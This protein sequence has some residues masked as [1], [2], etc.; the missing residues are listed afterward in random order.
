MNFKIICTDRNNYEIPYTTKIFAG[1]EIQVRIGQLPVGYGTTRYIKNILIDGL[2]KSSDMFMELMML[3]DALKRCAS[4]VVITADLHYLP[5]ARQD[6]VCSAGESYSLAQFTSLLKGLQADRLI[7]DDVHSKVSVDLMEVL[8]IEVKLRQQ[9]VL[10]MSYIESGSMHIVAPDKGAE[11]KASRVAY[12]TCNE[13]IQYHKIRNPHSGIIEKTELVLGDQ[14]L[15]NIDCLIV[16]D[17]CDGGRTFVPI[18]EDLLSRGAKSVSLCVTHAILPYGLDNLLEAGLSN[19]FY[20]N[21]FLD[22]DLPNM[23]HVSQINNVI[24]GKENE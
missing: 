1:G 3:C 15:T 22:E 19:F 17:I 21:S 13:L 10:V 7:F 16:D 6:R 11:I 24:K 23:H 4:G 9:H 12:Y 18:I 2:I 20:V 14:L 8:G 5:Y